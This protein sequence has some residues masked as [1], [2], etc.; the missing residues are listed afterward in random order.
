MARIVYHRFPLTF[1]FADDDCVGSEEAA[2]RKMANRA[3]RA[4]SIRNLLPILLRIYLPGYTPHDVEIAPGIQ[5]L[6]DKY[7]EMAIKTS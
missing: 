7:T 5:V 6:A 2:E 1:G 3:A 4:S